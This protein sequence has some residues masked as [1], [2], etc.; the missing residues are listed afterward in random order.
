MGIMTST[1]LLK[2]SGSKLPSCGG[3]KFSS[4]AAAIASFLPSCVRSMMKS[5][6]IFWPSSICATPCYVIDR[7]I[8]SEGSKVNRNFFK[9]YLICFGA[10]IL[11][12]GDFQP[13]IESYLRRKNLEDRRG[14]KIG[15][16]YC[17]EEDKKPQKA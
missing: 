4:K 14:T 6:N 8:D 7:N 10:T 9:K 2:A 5:K 15:A 11:H 17:A 16:D 1:P 3:L 13:R 12:R